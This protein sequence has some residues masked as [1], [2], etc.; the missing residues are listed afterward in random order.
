MYQR[1]NEVVTLHTSTSIIA[2]IKSYYKVLKKGKE[3]QNPNKHPDQVGF[4]P[5]MK[6]GST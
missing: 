1:L 3:I 6:G 5:V 4:I 2:P